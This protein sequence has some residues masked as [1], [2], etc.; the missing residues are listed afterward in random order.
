MSPIYRYA[1]V[2]PVGWSEVQ[3]AVIPWDGAGAPSHDAPE[4]DLFESATGTIA[5]A[6]AAPTTKSLTK[7]AEAQTAADAAEHPC[8]ATP[9]VDTSFEIAGDDARFTVKHCPSTGGIL[10]PM[11]A[12]IDDGTGYIFYFQ[13]PPTAP[14]SDGDAAAFK[15]LLAGVSFR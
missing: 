15:R 14:A 3:A 10:V 11:A 8:P 6:Y 12:V 9:E 1:V 4:A 5:W 7:L 2:L 13:H